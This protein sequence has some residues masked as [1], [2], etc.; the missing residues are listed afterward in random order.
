[1]Q[2]NR[3]KKSKI[4]TILLAILLMTSITLMASKKVEAQQLAQPISGPAPTGVT[5]STTVN[6]KAFL[7]FRP[8][9]IGVG[10]T[11]LVNLWTTPAP[12]AGRYHPDYKITITKPDGTKDV[13]TMNSYVA[14]GTAWFEY[15]TDQIGTWKI[16]FDFAGT[17]FPAG[18]YS[19]VTGAYMA[20]SNIQN[21]PASAYYEPDSTL[22]QTLTVQSDPVLS[23]P[24][25]P[26]P[27]DY[28][29]RPVAKQ[30]TRS[31]ETT[32]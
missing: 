7:S 3:S 23:W 6:T 30:C 19:L 27:T 18:N 10:Q 21:Y 22:E 26:L 2:K 29:N 15:V 16:K 32:N 1:M 8:N 13:I 12:G 4:L 14:D 25:S 28:W 5:P 11:F 31:L 9:P 17:Y 24:A 20:T